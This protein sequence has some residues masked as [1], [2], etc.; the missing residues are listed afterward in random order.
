MAGRPPSVEKI[1]VYSCVSGG[2]DPHWDDREYCEPSN[3]FTS[4]RL[5]AKV[6]KI[7]PH[8]YFPDADWT[9]WVDSNLE[10]K[11]TGE[12]IL[13]YFGRASCGVH[14]HPERETINQE[15]AICTKRQLDYVDA[16]EYHRDGE[17]RLA[18]CNLIVRQNHEVIN[19][20]SEKWWAQICA[21][22]SR[23]QLSFPYTLGRIAEYKE[24]PTLEYWRDNPVYRMH[25][26]RGVNTVYR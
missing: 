21:G 10:L 23:D 12:E 7:L 4:H 17:N 14:S 13:D 6:P 26:H 22:S 24:C 25:Q 15:I 1:V 5:R 16:M 3:R 18:A 8:L 19:C 9:I 11:M 20:L 2:Y